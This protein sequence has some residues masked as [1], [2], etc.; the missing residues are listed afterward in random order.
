MRRINESRLPVG[1]WMDAMY[2]I[3]TEIPHERLEK[4]RDSMTT[5]EAQIDPKRARETWG[6]TEDHLAMSGSLDTFDP[7]GKG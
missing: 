6:L 1:D 7:A 5:V 3:V 4:L 2:A